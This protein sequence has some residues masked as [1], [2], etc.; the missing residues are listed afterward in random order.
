MSHL[1]ATGPVPLIK[2]LTGAHMSLLVFSISFGCWERQ[3]HGFSSW[4]EP[5]TIKTFSFPASPQQRNYQRTPDTSLSSP[6]L[7]D[8]CQKHVAAILSQSEKTQSQMKEASFKYML[9]QGRIWSSFWCIGS[10]ALL[11]I[12]CCHNS[13]EATPFKPEGYI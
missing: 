11:G 6:H 3:S 2:H 5:A 10:Q 12:F 13:W 8:I 7:R 9:S 4:R 1:V